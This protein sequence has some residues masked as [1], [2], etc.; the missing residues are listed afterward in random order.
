[1]ASLSFTPRAPLLLALLCFAG[2]R[3]YGGDFSAKVMYLETGKP[4]AGQKLIFTSQSDVPERVAAITDAQGEARF[5]YHDS[6][7]HRHRTPVLPWRISV[8]GADA[9]FS[10]RGDF[11]VLLE[12]NSSGRLVVKSVQSL[13]RDPGD[14]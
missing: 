4:V 2:C 1:M 5:M 6:W 13:P 11:D 9:K 14:G 3:D 8:D 7:P 12:K 10:A